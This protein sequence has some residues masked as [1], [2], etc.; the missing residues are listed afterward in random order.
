MGRKNQALRDTESTRDRRTI[1]S[2]DNRE[3][4]GDKKVNAVRSKQGSRLSNI[5]G[6]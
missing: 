2:L 6:T 4:F 3:R 1:E 5:S